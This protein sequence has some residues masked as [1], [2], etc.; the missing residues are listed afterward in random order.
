MGKEGKER[1]KV[2][3]RERKKRGR[4]LHVGLFL[5]WRGLTGSLLE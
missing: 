1:K 5:F 4:G 2:G 3:R